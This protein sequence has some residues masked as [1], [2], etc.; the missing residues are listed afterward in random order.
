MHNRPAPD[1]FGLLPD[2]FRNRDSENGHAL[3]ALMQLLGKELQIV[4]Q[5]LDQLYDNWFIETCEQWV[6]PYI[7]DMVGARP[8]HAL[9]RN[10]G[11]GRAYI[12]NILGYRQAK[13]TAA[14]IEQIARDATGWSALAVEFFQTLATSQHINH[15]RPDALAFASVRDAEQA[16]RAH[17]PFD[18][19][20]HAASAGTADGWS[21]RYNI[22]NVGIM[23]WRNDA[24]PIGFMVT[25]PDGYLGGVPARHSVHGSGLRHFDRLGRDVPLY[26]ISKSDMS[27]AARVSERVVPAPLDRRR[28]HRDLEALKTGASHQ[29]LWFDNEPVLQ[30]RLDGVTLSADKLCCCS[31]ETWVDGAATTQWR[32]PAAA[33]EV[34]FDP[35]LGRISLHSADEG[36]PVE[37]SYAYGGHFDVGGGPYDR[38]ESVADWIADWFAEGEA[39]PLRIGVAARAADA[40]LT[41]PYQGDI[42]PTLA[43]AIQQWNQGALPGS[44]G[45]ITIVDNASY[46][47]NLTLGNNVIRI[48]PGARLAIVAA[49]NTLMAESDIGLATACWP[50]IA[51]HIAVV[52]EPGGV[53]DEGGTLLIDGLLVEGEIRVRDGALGQLS[54]RN[55]T[56]GASATGLSGGIFVK[57]GN[58][59]LSVDCRSSI[60]GKITMA[61]AAGGLSVTDSIV[62]SDIDL[63]RPPGTL[64]IVLNAQ[65]ADAEIH[66]STLFGRVEARSIEASNTIF[67]G[68]AKALQRQRGCVRFSYAPLASRL[69][70]R[71][72]CQPQLAIDEAT[73]PGS[74]LPT[75]QQEEI[76]RLVRPAIKSSIWGDVTFARLMLTCSDAVKAGGEDGAEMGVGFALG[77][78]YRLKNLHDV[79]EEFLPFGLVAAPIIVS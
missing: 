43:T 55:S 61:A 25:E 78:P 5:D 51:S 63:A 8:L 66:R 75:S 36:K 34:C 32:R 60:V 46:A 2:H 49:G 42:V 38:T 40:A 74:V 69:A 48:P 17:Q 53:A 59:G 67:L 23:V 76:D 56:L 33:G 15:V 68:V 24:Y 19:H 58:E 39:A 9:G 3:Q 14:V 4:E 37:T 18:T 44:R 64:P 77:E 12:A 73:P 72:R 47:E 54:I 41:L 28:L 35:E 57:D 52:G 16:R 7:A 31:L 29:S 30:I 1:V 10:E 22:P 45:L 79:I 13:G 50:H 27:I 26:N 70:R 71:F 11:G 6:L 21:G 20:C 65:N 62:G